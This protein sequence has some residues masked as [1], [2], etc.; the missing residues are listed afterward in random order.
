M[1][2]V[3]MSQVT[4]LSWPFERDVT[5][6]RAAGVRAIGVSIHKLDAIGVDRARALL[7]N[8]DLTVS[9]LT[10]SGMFPL[11]D[12]AGIDAALAHTRRHLA[13][14]ASLGADV[15]FILPGHASS[16]SWEEQAE[17][18]RPILRTLVA[19][20]AAARV[21]LAIEPVSQ[22]RMDLGFLHTFH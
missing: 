7:E 13:A 22:L 8:G 16:L 5:F 10:S 14:A 19:E 21:R 18:S 9:C 4:S 2:R 11:D 3:S 17:R 6:Y 20:A 12:P 1:R 15:L